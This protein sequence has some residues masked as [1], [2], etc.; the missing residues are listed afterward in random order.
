M[1]NKKNP[2]EL[3]GL[4]PFLNKGENHRNK[5]CKCNVNIESSEKRLD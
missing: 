2:L 1:S 3:G 5:V 4:K